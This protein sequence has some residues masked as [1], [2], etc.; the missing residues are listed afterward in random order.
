MKLECFLYPGWE[1]R[2]RP[3]PRR[4]AWMDETPESFAYRCLPLSIAN[5]H[6]W[7]IANPFGFSARWNGGCAVSDVE[8]KFDDSTR[9]VVEAPVSLFGEG[10]LTFHIPGLFRTEP[11]W[12]LWVG[13]APNAAKDGIAP[14]SGIIETDWSPYS[15]TMNWQFTRAG[16]WIRFEPDEAIAFFFPVERKM[17]EETVPSFHD[18]GDAPELHAA[19]EQ[20]SRSRDAFHKRMREAPPRDPAD[21]WQKL[22]YRGVCP[23]GNPGTDHHQTKLRVRDFCTMRETKK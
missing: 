17:I 23:A 13:G 22:Y 2:I 3:A 16:H 19:F 18:I 11:G 1:P 6:G 15:F 4:R 8:I 14:L 5:S 10:V 7:E 9:S 20:W 21:K 12:N